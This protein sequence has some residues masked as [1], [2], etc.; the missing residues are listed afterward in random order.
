MKWDLRSSL[1]RYGRHEAAPLK[2]PLMAS[3]YAPRAASSSRLEGVTAEA[4][5]GYGVFLLVDRPVVREGLALVLKKAGL[6]VVG[7]AKDGN[8]M[9]AHPGLTMAEAVIVDILAEDEKVIGFIKALRSRQL[10]SVVCSVHGDFA[11]I[12]A[13]FAA[14][15]NGYVTQSDEPQH[16]VEAIRAVVTGRNYV[17]P[18]AG[19]GLARKVAGLEDILPEDKFNRKQRQIYHLLAKGDSAGEIAVRIHVSPHTVES[20]CC[21]MIAQLDLPGMKALRRHAITNSH[22]AYA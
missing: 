11:Q 12:Q 7:Q 19:A 17:S 10:R 4:F 1:R 13:A 3:A 15:A 5:D 20:C 21:Q 8:E 14:G 22:R 2:T 18:C 6:V 9:T 16:L